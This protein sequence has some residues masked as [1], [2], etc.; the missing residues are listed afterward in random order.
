MKERPILFSGPMVRAILDGRK[1]QTRRIGKIQSPEYTELGWTE[2][3]HKYKGVEIIA[4]HRAYPGRGSARHAICAFP[5]GKI[6]DRLWVQEEHHITLRDPRSVSVR[7]LADNEFIPE[8]TIGP[9]EHAL[10]T[11]RKRPAAPTRARFMW[12]CLSRITLEITGGRVERLNDISEEDAIAEGIRAFTMRE[13]CGESKLYGVSLEQ[14]EHGTTGRA[15]YEILWESINGDGSWAANPW[16]W[17]VE[18]RRVA[19]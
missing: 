13:S 15:G 16:V 12:R 11:A 19:P 10:F 18:F 17:V 14:A 1:T 5:Y 3:G 8:V 9:R 7:Y 4:T 2:I 6:G